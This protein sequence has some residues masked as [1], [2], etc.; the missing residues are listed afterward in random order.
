MILAKWN[1]LAMCN[2][3][4]YKKNNDK[5]DFELNKERF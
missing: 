3:N 2:Y 5:I 1:L 4:L